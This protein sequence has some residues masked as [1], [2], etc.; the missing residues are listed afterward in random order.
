MIAPDPVKTTTKKATKKSMAP[1]SP[2]K[3]S[4]N[5]WGSVMYKGPKMVRSNSSPLE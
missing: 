2:T 5:T 3:K 4:K 1:H